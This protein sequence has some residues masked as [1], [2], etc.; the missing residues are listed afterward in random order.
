M[1]P[2][3]LRGLMRSCNCWRCFARHSSR[4]CDFDWKQ[5]IDHFAAARLTQWFGDTTNGIKSFFAERVQT[6][7]LC[8]DDV[9]SRATN[10]LRCS[11]EGSQ[12][13]P[14]SQLRRPGHQAAHPR[15][16]QRKTRTPPPLPHRSATKNKPLLVVS[17]QTTDHRKRSGT[18]TARVRTRKAIPRPSQKYPR[19]RTHRLHWRNLRWTTTLRNQRFRQQPTSMGFRD[20][21]TTT[22]PLTPCPPPEPISRVLCA[23]A[24]DRAVPVLPPDASV[25]EPFA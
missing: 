23:F 16:L 5:Q 13:P 6:K 15:R 2:S 9:A 12:Q 25:P 20:P 18:T 22:S 17:R 14:A 21:P 19:P 8:V 11:E 3:S 4:S 10:S 1:Q 7:E 24:P